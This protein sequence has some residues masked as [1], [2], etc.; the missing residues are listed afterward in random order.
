MENSKLYELVA[1]T[2]CS[3][4]NDNLSCIY[5]LYKR[6]NKKIDNINKN[7]YITKINKS[8]KE[9]SKELFK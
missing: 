5:Y 1:F 2:C 9:I 4:I 7:K 3:A 8:I 6:Y